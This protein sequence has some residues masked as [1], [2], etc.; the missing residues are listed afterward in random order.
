MLSAHYVCCIYLNE[1]QKTFTMEAKT[2]TPDQTAPLGSVRSG[3][4]LFA[5]SYATEIH[6]EQTTMVGKREKILIHHVKEKQS[7]FQAASQLMIWP[8]GY[9]TLSCTT[10]HE[11]HP[12]H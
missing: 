2:V 4:K 7:E 10:Q 5:I 8:R 11:I 6:K 12:A 3:S 9:K 1:L